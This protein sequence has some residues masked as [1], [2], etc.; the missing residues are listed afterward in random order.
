MAMN[1]CRLED[2]LGDEGAALF[3][4][5]LS[6]Q[7][8]E[9][10]NGRHELSE[11]MD[12]IETEVAGLERITEAEILDLRAEVARLTAIIEEMQQGAGRHQGDTTH[13]SKLS[14]L[15]SAR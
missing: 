10:G 7:R 4:E 8:A 2:M 6:G 3:E 9:T 12:R 13:G 1:E 15:P 5:E 11:R 14:F